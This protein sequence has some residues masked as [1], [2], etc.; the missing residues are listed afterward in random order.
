MLFSGSGRAMNNGSNI[1]YKTLKA[2]YGKEAYK[3]DFESLYFVKQ[4]F[5]KLLHNT[6]CLVRLG[7]TMRFRDM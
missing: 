5:P 4:E 3:T 6:I 2:V 7:G 1:D